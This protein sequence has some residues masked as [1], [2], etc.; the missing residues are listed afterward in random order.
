M[1]FH[2]DTR[3]FQ[4]SLCDDSFVLKC[5][6]TQHCKK[7]H[8]K[9][10][11]TSTKVNEDDCNLWSENVPSL[12]KAEEIQFNDSL[13]FDYATGELDLKNMAGY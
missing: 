11:Q 9:E 12:S 4:C 1:L 8:T 5:Y 2:S 6:L 3:P 7:I 10:I 13:Q